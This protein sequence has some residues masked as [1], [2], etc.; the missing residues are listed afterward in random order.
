MKRYI[1]Y[2]KD[3][4]EDDKLYFLFFHKEVVYLKFSISIDDQSCSFV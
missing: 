2:K 1:N 4:E 3:K